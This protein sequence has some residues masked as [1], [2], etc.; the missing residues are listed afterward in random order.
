MKKSFILAICLL[1]TFTGC[2]KENNTKAS[3]KKNGKSQEALQEEQKIT[4]RTSEY[5]RVNS[6]DG[7]KVRESPDLSSKRLTG[8]PY[9][10]VVKLIQK[11]PET[12]IDEITANWLEIELPQTIAKKENIKTGWVFGGYMT[13]NNGDSID[14]KYFQD[15]ANTKNEQPGMASIGS[16]ILPKQNE[17]LTM[18]SAPSKEATV[19]SDFMGNDMGI[20]LRACPN[21]TPSQENWYYIL[22]QTTGERGWIC[23]KNS[24]ISTIN[25]FKTSDTRKKF[26]RKNAE[27][28]LE[29]FPVTT[30]YHYLCSACLCSDGN[31]YVSRSESGDTLEIYNRLNDKIEYIDL[32]DLEGYNNSESKAFVYSKKSD[33][34]YF[35][36]SDSVYSY[37]MKNRNF[38]KIFTIDPET[39]KNNYSKLKNLFSDTSEDE[40]Y[41]GDSFVISKIYVSKDERY[42]YLELTFFTGRRYVARMMA[43]DNE[44]KIQRIMDYTTPEC[45]S[46]HFYKYGP[47]DFDENNNAVYTISNNQWIN[48]SQVVENALITVSSEPEN[49]PQPVLKMLPKT[50]YTSRTVYMPGGKRILCCDPRFCLY[51]TDANFKT[52]YRFATNTV[53]EYIS[54]YGN[55]IFNQ[56]KSICAVLDGHDKD[57]C[58][59]FYSTKTFNLLF[60][61]NLDINSYYVDFWWD[62]KFLLVGYELDDNYQT[63]SYNIDIKENKDQ[64]S[65]NEPL[66]KEQVGLCAKE[67]RCNEDEEIGYKFSFAPDGTYICYSFYTMSESEEVRDGI[68]GGYEIT[69]NNQVHLY[70]YFAEV[71]FWGERTKDISGFDRYNLVTGSSGID[72]T[73]KRKS[74][75]YNRFGN[76]NLYAGKTFIGSTYDWGIGAGAYGVEF[77]KTASAYPEI[78]SR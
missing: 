69:G 7:I 24:L 8:L 30:I 54:G 25:G 2:N 27:V 12:T 32:D 42:F 17:I 68:I 64:I 58:I 16:Y 63:I 76:I 22:N 23:S 35:G 1:L 43:Y 70:P 55:F 51:D 61:L 4:T 44:T 62:G 53:Y 6:S 47:V 10:T 11:G 49:W 21:K 46:D 72:L 71:P 73:I 20:I 52:S 40:Y 28:E 26:I 29:T 60:A 48:S 57:C 65:D 56:D 59:A 18:Y 14:S 74:V 36:W 9:K 37:S 13:K 5:F 15:S 31:H 77:E 39:Q 3:S 78:E 50:Q 38:E 33:A 67:F 66:N 45:D 19:I 75:E 34:V 41:L